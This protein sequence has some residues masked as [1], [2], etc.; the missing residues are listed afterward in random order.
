MA[1]S[2]CCSSSVTAAW[3]SAKMGWQASSLFALGEGAE[4]LQQ[5]GQARV[6]GR[7]LFRNRG[8]GQV[9]VEVERILR[10]E[11]LDLEV[12]DVG[13]H[14][15]ALRDGGIDLLL[16][17]RERRLEFGVEAVERVLFEGGAQG[18]KKLAGAGP[19]FPVDERA[20]L[21]GDLR[22]GRELARGERGFLLRG[23]DAER[24]E[25]L[26]LAV[27]ARPAGCR[28]SRRRRRGFPGRP[29]LCAPAD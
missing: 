21:R 7:G 19:F 15:L 17:L 22:L 16:V 9:Q 28:S 11:R 18:G 13:R 3:V 1:A 25:L 2:S 29:A 26:Q 12:A 5:I 4:D 27:R 10:D 20:Q 14:G 8:Q 6:V 24:L 23:V